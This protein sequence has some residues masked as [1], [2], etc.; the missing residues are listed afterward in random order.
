MTINEYKKCKLCQAWKNGITHA[1]HDCTPRRKII[2]MFFHRRKTIYT[3]KEIKAGTRFY[4]L[5]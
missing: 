4:E 5:R 2:A 1:K 3:L